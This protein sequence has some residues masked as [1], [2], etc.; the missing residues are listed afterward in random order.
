MSQEIFIKAS[1]LRNYLK[2]LAQVKPQLD[3]VLCRITGPVMALTAVGGNATVYREAVLEREP[4]DGVFVLPVAVQEFLGTLPEDTDVR[5]SVLPKDEVRIS[6]GRTRATVKT[7]PVDAYSVPV[8]EKE[9]GLIMRV[10]GKRLAEAVAAVESMSAVND[11]R[12]YLEGVLL[13]V[14]GGRLNVVATDGHRMGW[15]IM[16]VEVGKN[17]KGQAI[18]CREGVRVLRGFEEE[19]E[20]EVCFRERVVEFRGGD[21]H[22]QIRVVDGKYPDYPAVVREPGK[23]AEPI[24]VPEFSGIVRRVVSLA[25]TKK[26]T[27]VLR[28]RRDGVVVNLKEENAQAEDK[29]ELA[30]ADAAA[31]E[32]AANGRYLDDAFKALAGE[33]SLIDVAGPTDPIILRASDKAMERICVIMPVRM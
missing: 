21:Q 23:A 12:Y 32:V 29:L 6:A 17:A 2:A 25:S 30:P 15:M 14:R 16:P 10:S 26:A 28:R 1:E 5:L 7:V 27:V 11:V 19:D 18:L 3:G 4:G 8:E 20:V 22:V 33:K 9:P 13:D 24:P 31:W